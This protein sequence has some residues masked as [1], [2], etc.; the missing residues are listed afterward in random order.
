MIISWFTQP[1]DAN[2]SYYQYDSVTQQFSRIRL[3]LGRTSM[4]GNNGT[5][6]TYKSQRT[7]GFSDQRYSTQNPADHWS[8]NEDG[9]LC[10]DKTVL[11]G[12]PPQVGDKVYDSSNTNEFVHRGNP[13]TDTPELP[14]GILP[15]H[16]ALLANEAMVQK[17]QID[18]TLGTATQEALIEAIQ[19]KV[20]GILK[21]DNFE[22]VTDDLIL[23]KLTSQ[24]AQ[25]G[26]SAGKQQAQTLNEALAKSAQV[27]EW[28][29]SQ[30]NDGLLTPTTEFE[31]AFEQL[32]QAVIDA[33]SATG[34]ANLQQALTEISTA[35]QRVETLIGTLDAEQHAAAVQELKNA[36]QALAEAQTSA[37]EWQEINAEYEPLAEAESIEAYE[38]EIGIEVE[39]AV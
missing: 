13:V 33:Q 1:T 19:N 23:G 10:Y 17:A 5:F 22:Q 3:E 29:A 12:V 34:Q 35:Q 7:F 20:C 26:Q 14:E 38:Q 36:S 8:V 6:A 32:Q 21:V 31:N 18:L 4:S 16:L 37:S 39:A 30:M 28:I 9:K 11:R 2:A 24:I 27:N 25:I 15:K